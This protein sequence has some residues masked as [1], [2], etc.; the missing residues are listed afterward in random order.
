MPQY[1]V[2]TGDTILKSEVEAAVKTMKKGKVTGPDDTSAEILTALDGDNL[3][4]IIELC[5]DIYNTG[6]IPKEMRQSICIPL[7]KKHNTSKIDQ[8][9]GSFQSEFRPGRDTQEGIF[10]LR[11]A[12]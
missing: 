6:F 4:I 9:I 10:N 1:D 7:T 8:E 11:K 2:V 12:Y 3:N 5:N